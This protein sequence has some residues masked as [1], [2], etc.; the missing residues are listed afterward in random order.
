MP[1]H[2]TAAQRD[3]IKQNSAA[4]EAEIAVQQ[5]QDAL[6]AKDDYYDDAGH[7]FFY[8]NRPAYRQAQAVDGWEKV[9][10]FLEK[11]LK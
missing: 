5:R 6:V 1:R 7:G 2:T 4:R 9:F 3:R 10:S 8:H 11:H